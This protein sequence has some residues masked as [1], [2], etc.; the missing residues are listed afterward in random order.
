[1]VFILLKQINNWNEKANTEETETEYEFPV[2]KEIDLSALGLEEYEEE[3][4]REIWSNEDWD[5]DF[6]EITT[7]S[8]WRI[9]HHFPS[10]IDEYL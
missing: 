9:S 4:D 10:M 8:I 5:N 7:T 6:M 2:L 1:M 3:G